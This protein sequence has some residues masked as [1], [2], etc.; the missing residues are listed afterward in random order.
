MEFRKF[1]QTYVIRM[2]RGEEIIASLTRLCEQEMIGLAT[3]EAIGAVDHAVMCIYDVPTKTFFRKEFSGPM[4]IAS[5][6]GNVTRKDG[7]P[8]IHLH[9]TVCDQELRAYGGHANALTVSATCEMFVRVIEG[10]VG[11]RADEEIGLNM[12]QF[13]SIQSRSDG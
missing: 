8:Y 9:A 6:S 5:L 7:A 11:R 2:E 13:S 1:G 4:E 3:V 10:E 12:F